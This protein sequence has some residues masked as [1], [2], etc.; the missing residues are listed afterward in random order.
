MERSQQEY[1][2]LFAPK[3]KENLT[4][5]QY[6]LPNLIR[7]ETASYNTNIFGFIKQLQKICN[8]VLPEVI[9]I[10]DDD[11]N[12]Y[13]S[14]R[15]PLENPY[16]TFNVKHRKLLKER[17]PMERN[18]FLETTQD[19]NEARIGTLFA[20]RFKCYLQFNIFASGYA[21]VE[22]IME[23]FEDV[24]TDYTSAFKESGIVEIC[25]EEQLTDE[26]YE[27]YRQ[28]ASVRN[29]IFL[30]IFERQRITYD[31]VIQSIEPNHIQE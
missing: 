25:F 12:K 17:K 28:T 18:E 6:R 1:R 22:E 5:D 8:V 14:P 11:K 10:P 23:K 15:I 30:V 16:I 4:P 9:V 29:L 31:Q 21:L 2:A 19:V 7:N 13:I 24:I 26:T 27:T 3:E 20:Q